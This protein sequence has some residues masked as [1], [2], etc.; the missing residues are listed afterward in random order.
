MSPVPPRLL[1]RPAAALVALVLVAGGA[2]VAPA[3]ARA[4]TPRTV[5]VQVVPVV[6]GVH[7][8]V[9]GIE[10]VTDE[11][12][13]ATIEDANLSGV[14][15]RLAVPTQVIGSDARVSLDRVGINPDHGAFARILLAELDVDRLVSFSFLTPE[16]RPYPAARVTE[17]TL[18]DSLGRITEWKGAQLAGP[19]WMRASRPVRVA[20]GIKN[21]EVRYAVQSVTVDGSNAVHQGQIRFPANQASPW[22]IPLTLFD[23]T[24]TGTEF[25]SGA[26]IGRALKVTHPGGAVSVLPLGSSHQVT[27]ADQPPGD[28]K[29]RVTG[30]VLPV[31]ST[32][33]LS[34][35]TAVSNI[36]IT[37]GDLVT[38]LAVGGLVVVLLV[39][40]GVLI[41]RH[42]RRRRAARS[43][44]GSASGAQP[45]DGPSHDPDADA[46][47]EGTTAPAPGAGAP[48]E[49]VG[50]HAG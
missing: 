9:D 27:L 7:V 50:A 31:V 8:S 28:Y 44:G 2:V 37:A 12:G 24:V 10:G 32:V 22:P 33:H 42:R 1:R 39:V 35:T 48:A 41:R 30:G 38:L 26:P 45:P 16:K 23:L 19:N 49:A 40:A 5:T 15:Q 25:L 11:A 17:M 29:V 36:V 18:K 46:A 6:P 3:A 13:I 34:A 4:A 47:A 21:Q 43:A 14:N 20:G